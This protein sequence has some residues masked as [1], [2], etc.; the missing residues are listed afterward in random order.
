MS[1]VPP[2]A[3]LVDRRIEVLRSHAGLGERA[4]DVAVL[5]Q[6]HRQQDAL[7]RDI[8]V[9]G[10]LRDLLRLV[11]DADRIAV[12]ARCLRGAAASDRGHFGHQGVGFALR[13]LGVA[14]RGVDQPSR[15]ALLIVEQRLQQMRRRDPLVMLADRDGLRRL[16]EAARAIGELF[17]VHSV[18]TPL[19]S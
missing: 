18:E 11:E 15:H 4:A 13:G 1:A 12:D 9:A 16:Q 17:E 19:A 5:C 3:Q 2:A 10:L 14:T 7:D 8:A 6:R